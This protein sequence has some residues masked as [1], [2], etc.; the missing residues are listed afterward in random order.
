MRA[1]LGLACLVVALIVVREGAD[2]VERI[3]HDGEDP[4]NDDHRED[5]A[6]HVSSFRSSPFAPSTSS[7]QSEQTLMRVSENAESTAAVPVEARAGRS[8]RRP[9][10]ATP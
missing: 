1:L 3:R 10:G 6:E 2:L 5:D 8:A 7:Y 4:E 9:R